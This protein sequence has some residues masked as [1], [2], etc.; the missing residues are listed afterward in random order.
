MMM[1]HHCVVIP[2]TGKDA[3]K[4]L[5]KS[6]QLL[7]PVAAPMVERATGTAKVRANQALKPIQKKMS[8]MPW[9]QPNNQPRK[10]CNERLTYT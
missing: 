1:T 2:S 7:C 8:H 10:G 4:L 5:L 3:S 9:L 6:I